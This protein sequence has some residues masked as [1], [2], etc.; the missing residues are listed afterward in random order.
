MIRK[1][2]GGLLV[3]PKD[4]GALAEAIAKLRDDAA[5]RREL[6]AKGLAGVRE[7]YSIE[8]MT[9]AALDVYH[10]VA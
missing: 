10:G 3:P 8:A 1:T 9:R 4:P 7:H 5:L 6:G 2:G